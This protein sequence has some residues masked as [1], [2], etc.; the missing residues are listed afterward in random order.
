[1]IDFDRFWA[2]PG[3][4]PGMSAME[5]QAVLQETAYGLADEALFPGPG[6]TAQ[7]VEDWERAQG[8]RLPDVLRQA[9]GRQTGGYVRDSHVRVLPLAEIGRPDEELWEDASYDEEEVPD[10]GLVL[11][12]GSEDEFGGRYYL[13]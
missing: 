2:E 7:Q 12:F 9:L 4:L 3:I 1:M 8:V 5:S 11:Q 10:R 13:N 6:V